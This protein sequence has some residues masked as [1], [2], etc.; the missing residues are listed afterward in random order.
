MSGPD[1]TP[2]S[3]QPPR[4]R[5]GEKRE[6]FVERQIREG[7]ESGAFNNLPGFGKPLPELDEPY[8]EQWWIKGLIR[9]EQLSLLPPALEIRRVVEAGLAE[10]RALRHEGQVRRAVAALNEQ[11]RKANFAITWG[12]P[13]SQMPLDMEQVVADWKL[14]RGT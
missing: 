7:Y 10:I 1:K 5:P 9:R 4:Q 12:P 14:N 2:R 6:S 11:I 13:S 3:H 8:D